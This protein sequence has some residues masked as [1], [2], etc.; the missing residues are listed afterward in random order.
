M[1]RT[2][3]LVRFLEALESQSYRNFRLIVVDQNVDD[4]LEPVLA[5][6]DFSILHLRSEPGLSRARNVALG[7]ID[8]D[9]VGFPDD[10]CWY[11][12]DLLE[13]VVSLLSAR[14]ECDG[15]G[16]CAIDELG[17]PAAGFRDS[18]TGPMTR[19]NL[20]RRVS[21][22]T[23]FVRRKVV[24]TVGPF[25]EALGVGSGTPWGGA[26]DL[27]YIARS[28]R[29]GF[30]ICYEPQV[31]V[32]HPRKREHSAEPSAR[33]GY[34]Y[35]AGLGRA[36][37]ENRLPWWFALYYL[38]RSFG[39]AS[40]SLLTGHRPRAAFYWAVMRGRLHGWWGGRAA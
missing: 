12:R 5:G 36:L 20:W 37:R 26:E 31:A 18:G 16:G 1:A 27:D 14:P 15:V 22:Y 4:R 38:G 29:V 39:A 13:H 28:L 10:D 11:P 9:L 8:A 24:Q 33:Q 25:N 7:H 3:E 40:A 23:V 2:A 32:H 35:G 34:E 21:S 19:F 30:C 6:Y 17:R